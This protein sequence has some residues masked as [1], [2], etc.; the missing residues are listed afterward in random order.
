L[1]ASGAYRIVEE[2]TNRLV[3]SV[4]GA[5]LLS[6]WLATTLG[7]IL[8]LTIYLTSRTVA[9]VIALEKS[10]QETA[11][12]VLRYRLFGVL[13][14]AGALLLFWAVSYSSGSITLDR[15][16][17]QAVMQSK[18]TLFLPVQEHSISLSSV[19]SATLDS[20]PNSRRIRLVVSHGNDLGYPMW[21][22]RPGQDEAVDAMNRF[23]GDR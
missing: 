4:P 15:G 6:T 5:S 21:S 18:M 14:S 11:A 10:P 8:L 13:I 22:S 9:R 12:Y 3:I 19:Q 2:G 1:I 16:K 23:L 7:I 17:N 20:K